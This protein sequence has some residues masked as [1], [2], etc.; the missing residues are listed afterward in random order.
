MLIQVILVFKQ[1]PVIKVT[2]KINRP[3]LIKCNQKKMGWI[4]CV[5]QLIMEGT[6]RV[7]VDAPQV[8]SSKKLDKTDGYI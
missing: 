2:L 3:L 8:D 6:P 1:L 7:G 5:M 4:W